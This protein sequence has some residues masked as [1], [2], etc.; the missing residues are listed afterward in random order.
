MPTS[1]TL[2]QNAPRHGNA[3]P[4][5]LP[6]IAR[7]VAV[8]LRTDTAIACEPAG[9]NLG[10]PRSATEMPRAAHGTPRRRA[11]AGP[12]HDRQLQPAP[13]RRFV[14]AD[15]HNRPAHPDFAAR[16]PGR[17]GDFA[18]GQEAFP[19]PAGGGGGRGRQDRQRD[20]RRDHNRRRRRKRL[21][22][23]EFR[24]SHT[25]RDTRTGSLW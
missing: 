8:R 14:G 18:G 11:A 22:G 12:L 1:E 24:H 9:D 15:F 4:A 23:N 7:R 16:Q 3:V 13:E 19:H 10:H 6:G 17:Q 20:K 5:S 21:Q 25:R 2:L